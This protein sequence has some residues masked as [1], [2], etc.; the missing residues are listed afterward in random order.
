MTFEVNHDGVVFQK[1]LGRN[2]EELA[3]RINSFDPDRTWQKV[4]VPEPE[5]KS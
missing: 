1:D 3:K 2:T 4:D 5:P